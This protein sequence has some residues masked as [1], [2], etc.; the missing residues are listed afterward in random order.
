MTAKHQ[1]KMT[2]VVKKHAREWPD[3]AAQE[4]FPHRC[5]EHLGSDDDETLC[6]ANQIKPTAVRWFDQV[7]QSDDPDRKLKRRNED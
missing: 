3:C 7:F 2:G 1:A 6:R 5:G 4:D